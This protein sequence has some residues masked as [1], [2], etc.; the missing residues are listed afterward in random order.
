[1]KVLVHV[2]VLHKVFIPVSG[3]SNIN[4]CNRSAGTYIIYS[5]VYGLCMSGVCSLIPRSGSA[6]SQVGDEALQYIG[7]NCPDLETLNVQG[8]KVN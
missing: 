2:V 1:M 6:F 8:C 5:Q 3:Q 7:E 4:I